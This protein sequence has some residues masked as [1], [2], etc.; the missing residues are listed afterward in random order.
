VIDVE[1]NINVKYL[2]AEKYAKATGLGVEEV[3]RLCRIGE[4]DHFRTEKGY[5][6]IKIYKNN[7]N[8]DQYEKI[9]KENIELKTKLSSLK[10]ILEVN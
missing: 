2:S 10:R 9:L 4:L 3:K 5:Y 7:I 1:E 8:S 6:K